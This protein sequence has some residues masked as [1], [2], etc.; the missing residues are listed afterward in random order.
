[1]AGRL[2]ITP[3]QRLVI[4]Y[5]LTIRGKDYDAEGMLADLNLVRGGGVVIP[6]YPYGTLLMELDVLATRGRLSSE[7]G[8]GTPAA[9]G[10]NF[11]HFHEALAAGLKG[12]MEKTQCTP[13]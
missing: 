11:D 4:D 12:A 8:P 7:M 1:M 2:K 3:K 13:V 6:A 9:A 10:P 5:L